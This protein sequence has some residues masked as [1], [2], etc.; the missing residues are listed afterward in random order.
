MKLPSWLSWGGRKSGPDAT[1]ELLREIYGG[2]LSKTGEPVSWKT[3][4]QVST[5]LAC[6]RVIGQGLAQVP[7]KLYRESEDGLSRNPAKDHPLYYILH[8]KPNEWQTSFEL[9]E[10]IG[11]HMVLCGRHYSFINRGLGGRIREIIP[12]EPQSVQPQRAADGTITYKVSDQFGKVVEYPASTI[13]HLKG[14]SWNGW[15][16]M[17]AVQLAREAIGLAVA[18]EA[19]HAALHRNGISPAGTYSV[20]GTLSADQYKQLRDHISKHNAGDNKGFPLILDRN[21][22]WL[23][24]AMSGVD[25]QHLE[26]RRFQVE[27]VCRALGV[28][29][30]MVYSSDKA[31]TYA[32]A[33]QM[34]LAHVVHTMTP[35]YER[36]EQSIDTQLLLESD[37]RA[38]VYAKFVVQGLL[39]GAMKDTAEYLHK[40][41][42]DGILTRNEAR[43]LLEFNPL[44]GLDEPLTPINMNV[45]AEPNP[46]TEGATP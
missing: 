10:T 30:I 38:G 16:G 35:W 9:R 5:V 39:R 3:A 7:L 11:L 13:W 2:R 22:K 20:E 17:E 43:A 29:P 24:L 31:T 44:P 34:F 46:Q 25:A 40:L 18:T 14:L 23:S 26:T 6:A 36:L 19:Q 12:L 41:V 8:R 15:Q 28:M 27:E 37:S 42:L 33:E 32:S 1:L 45:G 21:A 4:L